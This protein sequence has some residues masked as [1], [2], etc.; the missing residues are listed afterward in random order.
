ML[1]VSCLSLYV[2]KC[3]SVYVCKCI[4]SL[5]P[6][7]QNSHWAEVLKHEAQVDNEDDL[8]DFSDDDTTSSTSREFD[9]E[10]QDNF[11]RSTGEAGGAC[12]PG[13]LS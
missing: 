7:D 1:C 13:D 4:A 12:H 8:D 3:V 2:C 10:T 9:G 6:A 11:T 5:P